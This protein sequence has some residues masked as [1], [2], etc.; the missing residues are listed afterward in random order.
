MPKLLSQEEVHSIAAKMAE[1]YGLPPPLIIEDN[2]TAGGWGVSVEVF[3]LIKV[4]IVSEWFKLKRVEERL[5][6]VRDFYATDYEDALSKLEWELNRLNSR[7]KVAE[8][9]REKF[10]LQEANEA[11]DEILQDS[12]TFVR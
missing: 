5:I 2:I 6:K 10:T 1:A 3:R 9:Y 12:N 7:A 8:N 4:E 11:L